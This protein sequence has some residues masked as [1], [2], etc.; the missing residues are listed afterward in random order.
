MEFLNLAYTDE[1]VINLLS[2]GVEDIHY[3]KTSDTHIVRT[4]LGNTNYNVE[5]WTIGNLFNTYSFEGTPDDK[6]EKFEEFNASCSEAPTLGFTPDFEPFKMQLAAISN[7]NEEYEASISLG[8]VDPDIY[9]PQVIEK[10]ETAGM[11]DVIEG[12]QTQ[13][14]AWVNAQ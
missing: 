1:Y 11:N 4:E 8:V 14:D 9:I 2:Y 7:V 6:W 13:Y 10:L 3:E 5:A 12:L